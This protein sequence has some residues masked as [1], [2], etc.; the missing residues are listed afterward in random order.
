LKFTQKKKIKLFRKAGCMIVSF[1]FFMLAASSVFA[2]ET[3]TEWTIGYE[4]NIN[5]PAEGE[6][7]TNGWYFMYSD[8]VNTDGKLDTSKVKECVWA[9]Q[10][11]CWMWYGYSE[12]WMPEMYAADDYDVQE[13]SCWWRMDDNGIMDPNTTSDSLRSVIAWEAPEDGTYSVK[14][15]YTAGSQ[16]YDWDG[17]T[18]YGGDGLTLSI[19][20]DTELLEKVF[21]D[22]VS[23]ENPDLSTGTLL[24]EKELKKGEKIYVSADPGETGG[25]DVATIKM[26]VT[27]VKTTSSVSET[28][29]SGTV[30]LIIILIVAVLVGIILSV[31]LS[32]KKKKLHN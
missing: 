3:D 28:S 16:S 32:G 27:Q 7:G 4:D 31:I 14:L 24:A 20:S 23:E 17:V 6:Q 9:D 18:Y 22:A 25:S 11:S 19:N 8:E 30:I 26:D 15:E 10:G 12:M 2:S 29:D 21:C 13:N 5:G 1:A